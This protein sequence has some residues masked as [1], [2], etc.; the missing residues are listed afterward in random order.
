MTAVIKL[1]TAGGEQETRIFSPRGCHA[2]GMFAR[3]PVAKAFRVWVLDVL[4]GKAAIP[5]RPAPK[6]PAEVGEIIYRHLTSVT[7]AMIPV[8]MQRRIVELANTRWP[9]ISSQGLRA[10]IRA[11]IADAMAHENKALPAPHITPEEH[12]ER[13]FEPNG[14]LFETEFLFQLMQCCMA[15]IERKHDYQKNRADGKPVTV[16]WGIPMAKAKPQ[17]SKGSQLNLV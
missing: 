7:A 13:W 4:E 16:T 15:R 2:L 12:I 9:V 3:T 10:E 11:A 5:A 1:P 14:H 8:A 6:T 17:A